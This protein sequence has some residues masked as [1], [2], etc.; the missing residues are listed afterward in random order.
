MTVA[1]K[2]KAY[3]H[4]RSAEYAV[5]R[6]PHTKSS[7]ATATAAAHAPGDPLATAVVVPSDYHVIWAC[8]AAMSVRTWGW[9]RKAS[10]PACFPI[11]TRVRFLQSGRPMG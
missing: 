8:C 3:L 11:A 6:H 9:P 5:V 4:K 7:M 10:S 1:A 2:L